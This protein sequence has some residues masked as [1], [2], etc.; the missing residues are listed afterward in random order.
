MTGRV[1]GKVGVIG[2][3]REE[4]ELLQQALENPETETYAGM[5][6]YSGLLQGRQV[7]CVKS[8]VGKVNAAVCTEAL[9][10]R[11]GADAV[12]FTGVAGALDPSLDIGDMVVSSNCM[13][14]DMDAT[15]LGFARGEIPFQETYD[16]P[17]APGLVRLAR[18]A[19]MRV[20]A[21]RCLVGRVLSGDQFI[22]D[23]ATVKWLHETLKGVCVEMEGAAVAQV[24]H[25]HGIPH[26]IIRSISDRA[27]GSAHV[28]FEVF[29]DKAAQ[30]SMAIVREMLRNM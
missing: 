4:I 1:I 29:K 6:F 9:I 25:M 7:V 11:F 18:E 10:A 26:V 19:C 27:D 17:S 23:R 24:C 22:A 2:A 16:F 28:N 14:H 12:V 30:K 3:M 20:H 21:G 8:G 13:Q 5:T 15:P